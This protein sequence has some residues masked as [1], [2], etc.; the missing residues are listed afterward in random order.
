[1]PHIRA[2]VVD[3]EPFLLDL[4]KLFL[5]DEEDISVD[6]TSS[7][8]ET[9]RLTESGEYDVV[10]SD[11]QMPDM[12]GL[13][14]LRSLRKRDGGLPLI[15]FSGLGASPRLSYRRSG[16]GPVPHQHPYQQ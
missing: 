1:M 11:F 15:L 2:L 13:E 6:V 5:E 10:V 9:F 3:D 7:G 16:D 4:T 8:E 14:L 12:D